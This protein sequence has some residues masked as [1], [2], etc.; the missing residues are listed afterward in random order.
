MDQGNF[1]SVIAFADKVE[2][3]GGKIDILVANAGIV[4][5]QYSITE[6]GWETT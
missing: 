2:R 1:S 5:P 4:N 3:E 6:D